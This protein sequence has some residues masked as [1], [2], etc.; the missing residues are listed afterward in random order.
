MDSFASGHCVTKRIPVGCPK[1]TPPSCQRDYEAL[2]DDH[3]RITRRAM[4][5]IYSY[6]HRSNQ[7][8]SPNVT[9]YNASQMRLRQILAE[10]ESFALN[11]AEW[12]LFMKKT[13]AL[14]WF[15]PED[16]KLENLDLQQQTYELG[17]GTTLTSSA[18]LA[19]KDGYAFRFGK[20]SIFMEHIAGAANLFFGRAT[21]SSEQVGPP[22]PPP[23]PLTAAALQIKG[24]LSLLTSNMDRVVAFWENQGYDAEAVRD[25]WAKHLACTAKYA[26]SAMND[27]TGPFA[28][29]FD[30]CLELGHQFGRLLDAGSTAVD[31]SSPAPVQDPLSYGLNVLMGQQND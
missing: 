12:T 7:P 29:D 19:W 8:S 16:A 1:W 21:G 11:S 20:P 24:A 30:E 28:R 17:G 10:V 4:L 22:S 3:I 26:E 18:A 5:A 15:D 6:L 31:S 23:L 25:L 13:A 9:F 27:V 14:N 2:M